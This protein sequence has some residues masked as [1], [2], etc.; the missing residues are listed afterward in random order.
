MLKTLRV[1]HTIKL[2]LK[3][4]IFKHGLL[5][6][7]ILHHT[8]PVGLPNNPKPKHTKSWPNQDNKAHDLFGPVRSSPRMAPELDQQNPAQ[9][10]T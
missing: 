6:A 7:H 2:T 3:P 8:T 9:T 10:N 1:K 5:H 4:E